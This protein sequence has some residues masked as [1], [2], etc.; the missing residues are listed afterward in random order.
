MLS[1]VLAHD[2][3]FVM[4]RRILK[5]NGP[6]TNIIRAQ[7]PR[8]NA[9]IHTITQEQASIVHPAKVGLVCPS[10]AITAYSSVTATTTIAT[11]SL[12]CAMSFNMS[13][14]LCLSVP[15]RLPV[16]V[17]SIIPGGIE[18]RWNENQCL[19]VVTFWTSAGVLGLLIRW[20]CL[21]ITSNT[22]SFLLLS[23][24]V[25]SPSPPYPKAEAEGEDED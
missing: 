18:W 2:V 11:F 19:V 1:S 20:W 3:C 22:I 16:V 13:L 15:P 14:T 5:Q 7:P 24:P 6:S 23:P 8:T 9:T 17:K 25:A 21:N 4:A 10:T 12:F